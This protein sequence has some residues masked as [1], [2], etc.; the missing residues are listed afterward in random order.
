MRVDPFEEFGDMVRRGEEARLRMISSSDGGRRPTRRVSEGG[1]PLK[2]PSLT[3]RVNR[4]AT[5]FQRQTVRV[6]GYAE[7]V[8]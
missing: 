3:R 2:Q 8:T 4:V 1:A 6:A 7:S 5:V